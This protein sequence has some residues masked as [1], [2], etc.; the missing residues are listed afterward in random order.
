[1]SALEE[2]GEGKCARD[3]THSAEASFPF[4]KGGK[5][6]EGVGGEGVGG[7]GEGQGG[8]VDILTGNAHPAWLK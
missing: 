6:R 1:M 5:I 8:G 2:K 4:N 7:G 3:K